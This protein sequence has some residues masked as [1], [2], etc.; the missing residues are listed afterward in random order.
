MFGWRGR[1]GILVPSPNTVM[2]S[3]FHQMAPKGVAIVTS[4]MRFP[5]VTADGIIEMEREVER[6]ARDVADAGVDLIVFGCTIASL[7]HG[8]GYDV[9]LEKKIEAAAHVGVITTAHAVR[10]ALG[11][12]GISEIA[13]A[14]PYPEDMNQRERDFLEQAGFSVRNVKGLG[15]DKIR[16]SGMEFSERVYRFAK[17]TAGETT[18]DGLFISCTDIRTIDVIALLE[19]D[20]GKPV[21]SS[22][23]A[24]MWLALEKLGIRVRMP[25]YGRLMSQS[26]D[27]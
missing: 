6:A 7:Y 15:Y 3:E 24:S 2:E 13:V 5:S 12:L 25:E 27:Y 23:Q 10:K 16:Y 17:A 4:R 18:C 19:A 22:N 1:I 14:T 9:D 11:A 26:W 8:A 20:L 21:V